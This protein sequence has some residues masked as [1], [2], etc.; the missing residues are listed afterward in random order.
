M[1]LGTGTAGYKGT[2]EALAVHAEGRGLYN[3]TWL[4][5]LATGLMAGV[6]NPPLS[7]SDLVDFLQRAFLTRNLYY[8]TYE[9]DLA[10]EQAAKEE[11]L[12]RALRTVRGVPD[13]TQAG[14]CSLLDRV[15]LQGYL[16][17]LEFLQ[18]GKDIQKLLVGKIGID[19]LP[20]ME[21]IRLLTPAIPHQHLARKLDIYAQIKKIEEHCKSGR[22]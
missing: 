9:T 16:D 13:L 6:I 20:D 1:L 5:T 2:E 10:A 8:Q 15:Y 22:E 18:E 19:D 12:R 14:V 3:R 7:F 11:A 4:G 17:L 21:Q